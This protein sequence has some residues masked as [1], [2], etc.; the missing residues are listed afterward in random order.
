MV[1]IDAIHFKGHKKVLTINDYK[2]RIAELT[3]QLNVATK[4]AD[5]RKDEIEQWKKES[6]TIFLMV[7]DDAFWPSAIEGRDKLIDTLK[8][9]KGNE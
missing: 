6:Y 2:Q 4:L 1:D 3:E 8:A 7:E 9:P 5:S